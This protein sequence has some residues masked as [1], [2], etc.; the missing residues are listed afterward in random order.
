M[1]PLDRS[2]FPVVLDRDVRVIARA[3]GSGIEELPVS[4]LARPA[5]QADGL[6]P[7]GR[8]KASFRDSTLFVQEGDA[9]PRE[10]ARAQSPDVFLASYWAPDSSRL[11]YLVPSGQFERHS[12]YVV[13]VDG[14]QPVFVGESG[15]PPGEGADGPRWS[16]DASWIA[17]YS[18]RYDGVRVLSATGAPAVEIREGSSGHFSWSPDSRSLAFD[19]NPSRPDPTSDGVVSIVVADV[20]A[21]TEV[22]VL[23]EGRWPRWSPAGDR[24][25]FKRGRAPSHVFTI[26][27]NGTGLADL[28]VM[29]N[30]IYNDFSWSDDGQQIEFVRGGPNLP[31][32]AIDLRTARVARTEAGYDV[33]WSGS[34]AGDIQIS[35]DGGQIAFPGYGADFNG[36]LLL[37]V[38]SGVVR[39]LHDEIGSYGGDVLWS[40]GGVRLAYTAGQ[41]GVL[42]T[43]GS[44][45]P[46]SRVSALVAS[47]VAWS[48]DGERL[49]I[50][51]ASEIAIVAVLGTE[52]SSIDTGEGAAGGLAWSPDRKR[53]LF[54]ITRVVDGRTMSSQI[55]MAG[56]N[57]A[58]VS[59]L[60]NAGDMAFGARWSPDGRTIAYD[61]ADG[62]AVEVWLADADGAN[63]R[64]LTEDGG[65]Q[66]EWSPEGTMIAA[67]DGLHV[68]VIDVATGTVVRVAEAG[69][70]S[71]E[72]GYCLGIVVRW[73]Q[74]SRALHV[75][76][77]CHHPQI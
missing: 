16:P 32:Y 33:D 52:D 25:A 27:P 36:W 43:Q 37:A 56:V 51:T 42:I 28:G 15:R 57:G 73:S 31:I 53:L 11:A 63:A 75:V 8:F 77:A 46:V 39:R 68:N 62:N 50:A 55:F 54:E 13:S 18:P 58:N 45:L 76:L 23:T 17:T 49:A 29:G 12:V 74:D 70:T 9:A 34:P 61:R 10:I 35:P 3:D 6:S 65:G 1:P 66:L 44:G 24:I 4:R 14:G 60:T 22:R 48:P 7:D 30:E 40:A 19:S 59:P 41:G 2:L 5:E 71:T 67:V 20:A 21:P 38:A 47:E 64:R 69:G 72:A 26:R